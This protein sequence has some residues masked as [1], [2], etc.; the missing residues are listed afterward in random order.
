MVENSLDRKTRI[1]LELHKG[2]LRLKTLD[3]HPNILVND[4]KDMQDYSTLLDYII[5]HGRLRERV[6]RKIAQ[7]IATGLLFCHRNRI[8]HRDIK[9]ENILISCTGDVK[10]ANFGL[11]AV[12]D[13]LGH[14]YTFCGTSYF[15]AP[16]MLSGKPYVGPEVDVWNF[17][18]VLYILVCGKVPFNDERLDLLHEKVRRGTVQYPSHLSTECRCL[19][20]RMLTTDP[21][22][23][24]SLSDVLSHPWLVHTD[25]GALESSTVGVSLNIGGR[26]ATV[27]A[28]WLS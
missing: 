26:I 8:V 22:S 9:V 2:Q 21:T 5:V 14:L 3:Y 15:P 6:A 27:I 24:V 11:C 1:Q 19:L 10:I 18:I 16:E 7:Q 13:R 17:G 20:S 28:R 25:S 4:V 12:F 23:R